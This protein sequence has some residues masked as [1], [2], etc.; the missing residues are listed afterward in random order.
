MK[1]TDNFK[2]A[3]IT[4]KII[5]AFYNVYNKLGHGFLEKVYQNSLVIEMLKYG[6]DVNVQVP[7]KVFYD[8]KEVGYYFA[9]L[10]VNDVVIVELKASEGLAPEHEAQLVNYLKATDIEV[11][12][13]LNFGTKPSF[14]R[15]V[16]SNNYK[17]LI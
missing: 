4:N 5:A 2:H 8:G 16:F 1:S 9:D 11:G 7:I 15:K 6:L 12:I 13:L 17:T 10:L 3:E 14:K